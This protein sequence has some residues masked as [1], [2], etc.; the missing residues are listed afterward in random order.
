MKHKQNELQELV[1][2][3]TEQVNQLQTRVDKLDEAF[4]SNDTKY[5]DDIKDKDDIKDE[6]DTNDEEINYSEDSDPDEPTDKPT[7]EELEEVFCKE[8]TDFT[9]CIGIEKNGEKCIRIRRNGDY[10][11]FHDPENPQVCKKCGK[12]L[13]AKSGVTVNGRTHDPT[14]LFEKCDCQEK[15]ETNIVPIYST[16]FVICFYICSSSYKR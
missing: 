6:D 9:R 15:K 14:G 3:L 16:S 10:C 13:R 5:E 1:S 8:N 11:W 12:R 4:N 7:E 2:K